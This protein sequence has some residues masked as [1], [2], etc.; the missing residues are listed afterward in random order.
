M[1]YLIFVNYKTASVKWT[2]NNLV[3]LE[4]RKLPNEL[5]VLLSSFLKSMNIR[6]KNAA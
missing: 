5:N 1:A 4:Y 3:G 6:H 2:V